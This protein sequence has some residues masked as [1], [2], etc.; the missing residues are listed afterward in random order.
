MIL[1]K[2]KH[3]NKWIMNWLIAAGVSYSRQWIYFKTGN[4]SH[5]ISVFFLQEEKN[6]FVDTARL[7]AKGLRVD[8]AD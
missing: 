8:G 6:V 7:A 4:A 3:K 5:R 2:H 1:K